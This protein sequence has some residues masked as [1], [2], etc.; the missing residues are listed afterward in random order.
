MLAII[1]LS[2]GAI[3]SYIFYNTCYLK[4]LEIKKINNMKEIEEIKEQIEKYKIVKNILIEQLNQQK[5]KA[6]EISK[7]VKILQKNR[8]LPMI[9]KEIEEIKINI[10]KISKEL[11]DINNKINNLFEEM[12]EHKE[13]NL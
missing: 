4:R 13:K 8:T 2:G 3:V 6:D 10:P 5:D 11:F 1:Y 9:I 12:I 7:E